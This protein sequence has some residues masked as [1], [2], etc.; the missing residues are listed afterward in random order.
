VPGDFSGAAG[1]AGVLRLRQSAVP[2]TAI[3][4]ANDAL[5]LGALSALRELRIAVPD[6]VAVAGFDNISS[7]QYSVPPLT[8]VEVSINELGARAVRRL[9][10]ALRNGREATSECE[11]LPA[12]LVIRRSCGC[13][14]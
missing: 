3:F 5:A 9:V 14:T 6:A 4:A 10:S 2:P 11:E 1:Y 8:T 12:Q 13:G 7:T